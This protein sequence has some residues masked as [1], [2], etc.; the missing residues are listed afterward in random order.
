LN[1]IENSI[2]ICFL[3]QVV[4]IAAEEGVYS[5]NLNELHDATLELVIRLFKKNKQ[6]FHARF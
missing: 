6:V 4:L 5:L 2:R 3:D 1:Y